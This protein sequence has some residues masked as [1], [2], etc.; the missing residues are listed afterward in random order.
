MLEDSFTELERNRLDK[1]HDVQADG[2][3]PYPTRA[4]QTHT[5]QEAIDAFTKAEEAGD[6]TPIKVTLAG[7]LRSLRTMGKIAFAHI[8]D[9]AGRIQLFF[10]INDLGEEKMAELDKYFD[11]GDFIQA[12]GYMFR[13]KRGEISLYVEDYKLLAKALR[14][15]PGRQRRSR[16]R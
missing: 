10:R 14:P 16:Q 1:L 4:E 5:S 13:T 8:D 12:S 11:L 9:R 2:L 15:L 6:E 3:E 7:R